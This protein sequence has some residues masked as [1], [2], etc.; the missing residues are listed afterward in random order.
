MREFIT[1]TTIKNQIAIITLDRFSA[2]NALSHALIDELSNVIKA[3]DE[4][5]NILCTIITGYGD[6]AFC[7]GADLKERVHM[8]EDEVMDT[9]DKIGSLVSQ[10]EHMKMAVIAAINGLAFGGGLELAIACDIR[11]AEKQAKMGLTE[12]SLAVIPGAGGTQRLSRLIGIAHT[13][14]MIYS[15]QPID[16]THA[17]DIGLVQNVTETGESLNKAVEIAKRI[18]QNGPIAIK[19]AKKAIDQGYDLPIDKALEHERNCYLD[20]LETTD[21]IE[22]LQSFVEKRKPHYKEN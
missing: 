13:K 10:I 15:A 6:K 21:R 9:V 5:P 3:F 22:G 4:D 7:A 11:I 16:A 14:Y 2:L 20:T 19:A 1:S 17:F 12:T 18:T 8:T